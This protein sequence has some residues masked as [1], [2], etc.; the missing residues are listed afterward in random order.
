M[1][2]C[3]EIEK[4]GLENET[5]FNYAGLR[6]KMHHRYE[7]VNTWDAVVVPT[8][9]LFWKDVLLGSYKSLP[10]AVSQSFNAVRVCRPGIAEQVRSDRPQL[11]T[12]LSSLGSLLGLGIGNFC[13]V[14]EIETRLYPE[15]DRTR[16][17]FKHWDDRP[18]VRVFASLSSFDLSN[19][20]NEAVRYRIVMT[21]HGSEVIHEVTMP[22]WQLIDLN[23]TLIQLMIKH[24]A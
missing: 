18:Q 3:Q 10:E 23:E 9:E 15:D 2:T 14:P 5:G 4:L 12:V 7:G 16:A 13:D 1:S 17:A 22:S 21:A 19:F 11:L 8:V 6:V 20:K 24:F